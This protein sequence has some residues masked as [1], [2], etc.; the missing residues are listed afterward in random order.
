VAGAEAAA[1]AVLA[2]DASH[3]LA[4]EVMRRLDERAAA[5]DPLPAALAAPWPS[6]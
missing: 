5:R 3:P 4:R 6:R 1:R 2:T